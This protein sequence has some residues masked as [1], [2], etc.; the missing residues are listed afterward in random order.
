MLDRSD[1]HSYQRDMVDYMRSNP[2]CAVFA[3]MGSG[4]S[5]CTLTA[6]DDLS[7]VEDVWPALIL[8]PK[9][10]ARSVWPQEPAGWRHLSHLKVVDCTGDVETRKRA[11]ARPAHAYSVNYEQLEWVVSH[12]GDRW[13]FKTVVADE[14]TRLKSMRV[15][16]GGKNSGALRDAILRKIS[17]GREAVIREVSP[18]TPRFIGLTGT[19]TPNGLKD[20]WG[21]FYAIDAGLRL[22][23][24]YSSF[25]TRWF[26]KGY[27]GFSVEPMPHAEKEIHDKLRDVCLTVEGLPVDQPIFNNIYVDLPS[28]VRTLYKRMER[29]MFAEIE[30]VGIEAFNAAAKSSKLLQLASGSII[31]DTDSKTWSWVHDAKLDALESVVEEANGMPVLVAFQFVADRERILKRFP[32][33]HL[34]GDDP[35]EI[36]RWNNGEYPILVGH[37]ASMG[38]G[39]QL[40][41]GGNILVMFGLGWNLE[42][43]LQVI[44]RLGPM[45]Q[46]QAGLNRPVFVHRLLARDTLDE[47]TLERMKSK[48]TV[49][50]ALL[51]AMRRVG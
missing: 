5:V 2:R 13:P 44:E 1:L 31:N 48:A 38:H 29:E 34:L 47:A 37:P 19:P 22:G 50:Q 33:A 46:K 27:D 7:L 11:F 40:A 10:V 17:A 18:R 39:I 21:Q 6:L 9:R 41:R 51:N 20:L 36:D 23:R 12:F 16:Q 4:K 15:E 26:R 45:R 8:G 43:Y 24:T 32:K 30:G 25:E 42:H 49:Q 35:K 3:A 14:L 28:N